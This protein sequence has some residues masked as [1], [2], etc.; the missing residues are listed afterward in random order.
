[1]FHKPITYR[2]VIELPKFNIKTLGLNLPRDYRAGIFHIHKD[3]KEFKNNTNCY[4]MPY[5]ARI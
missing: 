1:M 5:K 4:N 3:L 2:S